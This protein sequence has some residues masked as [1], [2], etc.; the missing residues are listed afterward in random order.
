MILTCSD[1]LLHIYSIFLYRYFQ[2]SVSYVFQY[3]H[4][5]RESL[6]SLMKFQNVL[7]NSRNIFTRDFHKCLFKRENTFANRYYI[8]LQ[9]NS[10][11]NSETILGTVKSSLLKNEI[12]AINLLSLARRKVY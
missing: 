7:Y 5:S 4:H 12:Y 11:L 10:D 8:F 6:R 2:I 1:K 3:N 9:S